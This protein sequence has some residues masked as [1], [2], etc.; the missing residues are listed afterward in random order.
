MRKSF[1][2]AFVFS[3][4]LVSCNPAEGAWNVQ[5]HGPNGPP[6]PLNVEIARTPEEKQTGLMGRQK[7]ESDG[8]LFL[9]EQ[10]QELFFWMKNT[11][12]PLDIMYFDEAG[13][14]VSTTTMEP[15]ISDPCPSYP[16]KG[17]AMYALEVE[18]GFLEDNAIGP[19]W[20]IELR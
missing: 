7:L 11:L 2:A 4:A 12:I 17:E 16:S 5:L 15:C 10:E 6:I 14:L 13:V 1:A 18:K 20:R 19:G 3:L 8:M 9:F